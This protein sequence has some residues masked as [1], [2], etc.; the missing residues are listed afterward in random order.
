MSSLAAF[1][2]DA[3]MQVGDFYPNHYLL[4]VF[5]NLAAADR[6]KNSLQAAPARYEAISVSGEEL[7]HFAGAHR[8][9]D[10]FWG[11]LM[12]ELSRALET[13]AVYSDQDLAAARNGAGFVVV[14]CPDETVKKD[15]WE[16]LKQAHPITARYYSPGGIEHL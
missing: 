4:A 8:V 9:D 3:E 2:K 15:V 13:G 6:A 7:V 10:G 1:F 12:T 14:F 11:A 5:P 16:L